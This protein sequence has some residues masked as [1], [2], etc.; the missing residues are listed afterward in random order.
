MS[1]PAP[2]SG[3]V[4]LDIMR[5]IVDGMSATDVF[6]AL[7]EPFQRLPPDEVQTPSETFAEIGSSFRFNADQN[8]TEVWAY[9]HDRRG[10]FKLKNIL[11][12]YLGFEDGKLRSQWRVNQLVE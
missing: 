11:T 9:R 10:K 3:I 4:S 5:N 2:T 6:Q 12:S 7:G 8:L 1:D